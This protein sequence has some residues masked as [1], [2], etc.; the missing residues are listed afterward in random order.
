MNELVG[1]NSYQI[2]QFDKIRQLSSAAD[3]NDT[4]G[5]ACVQVEAKKCI[6][7]R[8]GHSQE[9]QRAR[10]LLKVHAMRG[11]IRLPLKKSSQ[12]HTTSERKEWHRK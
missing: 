5:I 2:R 10:F 1:Q 3:S 9:R 11:K 8:M 12:T 6:F 4:K 7:P